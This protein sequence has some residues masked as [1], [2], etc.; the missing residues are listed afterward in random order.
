V[1]PEVVAERYGR[2]IFDLGVETSA[3]SA[4]VEEVHKLADAYRESA[5]LQKV[6][7]NPLIPEDE[8]V[9]TVLEIADRLGLSQLAKNAAGLLA[10]RRRMFALPAIAAELDRLSDEK[11]GIARATVISAERLTE[12]YEQRLTQ[13]LSAMTGKKIVLETKQ[14]PELLAGLVVRI[15]DQVIDGSA[16]A[17]IAE[18]A[19]QLLSA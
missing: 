2:A 1:S 5:E 7:S 13:E 4:L 12:A 3:L 8:R 14:D 10:R 16:K 18:L 11:A 19:S 17:R 6:V 9:A 15:G